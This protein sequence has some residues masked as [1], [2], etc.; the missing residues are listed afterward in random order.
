[1]ACDKIVLLPWDSL[2]KR[3][4]IVG[5]GKPSWNERCIVTLSS[6]GGKKAQFLLGTTCSRQTRHTE[7]K[8]GNRSNKLFYRKR[9]KKSQ[10]THKHKKT[11]PNKKKIPT[12]FPPKKNPKQNQAKSQNFFFFF[13][14]MEVDLFTCS[15]FSI[16]LCCFSHQEKAYTT[17][18]NYML[19]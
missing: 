12:P 18:N 17:M 4:A 13:F 16:R 6:I 10:Q 5:K 7:V 9:N 1:M 2:Y 14:L 19:L 3:L 15:L 8:H 11:H